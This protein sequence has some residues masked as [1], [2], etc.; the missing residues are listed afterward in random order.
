MTLN[1]LGSNFFAGRKPRNWNEMTVTQ[2]V[3]TLKPHIDHAVWLADAHLYSLLP[4]HNHQWIVAVY[5]V[6]DQLNTR[7]PSV[8]RRPLLIT[9]PQYHTRPARPFGF[10]YVFTFPGCIGRVVVEFIVKHGNRCHNMLRHEFLQGDGLAAWV[11]WVNKCTA[12]KRQ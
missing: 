7:R 2:W 5:D 4:A 11:M 10:Y 1:D 3:H 9:W 8:G 6:V 12:Y